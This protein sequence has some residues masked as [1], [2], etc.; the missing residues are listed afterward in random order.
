M[1][2]YSLQ[3]S[4]GESG[5]LDNLCRFSI[6]LFL[7]DSI[8][9]VYNNTSVFSLQ[10]WVI[11]HTNIIRRYIL[12]QTTADKLDYKQWSI[13]NRCIFSHSNFARFIIGS[14][15]LAGR[16]SLVVL[17]WTG[18][19]VNT[20]ISNCG[21]SSL[22]R[23]DTTIF[24]WRFVRITNVFM[25][26]QFTRSTFGM[27]KRSALWRNKHMEYIVFIGYILILHRF[28]CIC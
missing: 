28:C 27:R 19:L 16:L 20:L 4:T 7:L 23:S 26:L 12:Q 5:N 9:H 17:A 15:I 14:T 24:A 13:I 2:Y 18:V 10:L 21:L 1:Y 8:L 22:E 6:W 25:Q 3:C 11:Q